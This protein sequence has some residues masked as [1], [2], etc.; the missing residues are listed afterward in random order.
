MFAY[1]G[2]VINV[3]ET[4]VPYATNWAKSANW[5]RTAPARTIANR[6]VIHI[7]HF[8]LIAGMTKTWNIFSQKWQL[9]QTD[10]NLVYVPKYLII[11]VNTLYL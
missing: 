2:T 1:L 4:N 5:V 6:E 10:D 8:L 9:Q 11:T 3:P 7:F